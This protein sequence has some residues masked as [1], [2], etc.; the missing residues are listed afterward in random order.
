MGS[1]E[2][3]AHGLERGQ[4]EQAAPLW[5][6]IADGSRFYFVHSY[7]VDPDDAGC[8]AGTTDYG[9]P[10]TSAVRGIISLPFNATRRRVPSRA[11]PAGKLH[12]L[13]TLSFTPVA[14]T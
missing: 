13:E 8:I 5:N 7:F 3:A 4:A 9:I 11:G 1:A 2:G 6:G 12:Q 14:L 10:F